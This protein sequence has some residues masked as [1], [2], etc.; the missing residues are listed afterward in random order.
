MVNKCV[1]VNCRSNY[2]AKKREVQ[3]E[4]SRTVFGFS[5]DEEQTNVW[6]RF[7]N[8]KDWK[9]SEHSGI[10]SNRFEKKY[11][12]YNGKRVVLNRKMNPVPTI[13][14]KCVLKT[15]IPP[16]LP[17]LC[18]SRKPPRERALL[19]LIK[20]R[21]LTRNNINNIEDLSETSSPDGFIFKK[22]ECS[23]LFYRIF[24]AVPLPAWFN[25]CKSVGMLQNFVSG[26]HNIA[27]EWPPHILAEI[28]KNIYFKPM[29]RSPYSPKLLK[30]ALMQ[31]N[32]SSQ[33]YTI[34]VE[35]FPLPSLSL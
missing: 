16:L 17:A 18:S 29:G 23:E 14:V 7:V 22:H 33:A 35:Q 9:E 15:T 24:Y 2:K 28:K 31:R 34:L 19:F 21:L 4:I 20:W 6:I 12:K 11:I 5:S 10:C 13:Y 32:M 27:A 30:F 1:V 26:M 3:K 25:R 8:R